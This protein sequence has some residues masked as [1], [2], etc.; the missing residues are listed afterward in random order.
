[1]GDGCNILFVLSDTGQSDHTPTLHL[2][3]DAPSLYRGSIINHS[4]L[5]LIGWGKIDVP[6]SFA[7]PVCSVF[8]VPMKGH[9]KWIGCLGISNMAVAS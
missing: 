8:S 2:Y 5:C 9:S 6:S 4:G 1:M 3:F 7:T